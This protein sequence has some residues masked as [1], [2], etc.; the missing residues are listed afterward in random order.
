VSKGVLPVLT[1]AETGRVELAP[2][3][4]FAALI[5]AVFSLIVAE[6]TVFCLLKLPAGGV[7]KLWLFVAALVPVPEISFISKLL[8]KFILRPPNTTT[9]QNKSLQMELLF[10]SHQA[11]S[12]NIQKKLIDNILL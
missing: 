8:E 4:A 7:A 3:A 10:L 5:L 9:H 2:D 12:K 11:P 1:A 6:S